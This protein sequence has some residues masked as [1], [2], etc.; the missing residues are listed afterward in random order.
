MSSPPQRDI[1]SLTLRSRKALDHTKT[2]CTRADSLA[3]S[4]TE[5]VLEVCAVDAKVRWVTEGITE[6]LK[7]RFTSH[8]IKPQLNTLMVARWEC[9]EI[10][11]R[12][13]RQAGT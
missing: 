2:L 4:S 13:E 9:R 5:L 8:L 6:Q 10:L 12:A 7:A 3:K 1:L 11:G